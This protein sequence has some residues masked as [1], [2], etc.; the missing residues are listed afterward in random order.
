MSVA[1][2]DSLRQAPAG[3]AT[4]DLGSPITAHESDQRRGRA[5]RR[6]PEHTS[7]VHRRGSCVRK[8]K[9]RGRT[10]TA[11]RVLLVRR[12]SGSLEI[13]GRDADSRPS[14]RRRTPRSGASSSAKAVVRNGTAV[15]TVEQRAMPVLPMQRAVAKHGLVAVETLPSG[16]TRRRPRAAASCGEAV[17]PARV[18]HREPSARNWGRPFARP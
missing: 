16:T 3:D 10:R 8:Q 14:Q 12:G 9:R 5:R 2:G 18:P 13:A 6:R 7:P 11:S 15:S 1:C 17:T 4:R